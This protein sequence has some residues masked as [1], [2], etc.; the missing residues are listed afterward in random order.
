MSERIPALHE[1]ERNKRIAL[2][3]YIANITDYG[4]NIREV[5]E[6]IDILSDAMDETMNG[7]NLL[8]E[9]IDKKDSGIQR[10]IDNLDSH[11]RI[12][13]DFL[14]GCITD[15]IDSGHRVLTLKE[16]GKKKKD[17]VKSLLEYC[18]KNR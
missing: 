1:M 5:C 13:Y 11:S 4:E 9:K 7:E 17:R 18:K 6:N 16:M 8:D 14:N 10:N 15:I 2:V 12:V 3:S